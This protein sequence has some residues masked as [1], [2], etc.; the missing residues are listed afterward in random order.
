M[1][2]KA[3]ARQTE[4][5][6]PFLQARLEGRALQHALAGDRGLSGCMLDQRKGRGVQVG[7]ETAK[8][9]RR[10]MKGRC[11]ELVEQLLQ[12]GFGCSAADEHKSE[13]LWKLPANQKKRADNCLAMR[14]PG[15][16]TTG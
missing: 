15:G 6:L 5:W 12:R 11:E 10:Y 9:A 2:S 8:A 13:Q 1:H 7:T 14:P 3:A 16:R 4:Q